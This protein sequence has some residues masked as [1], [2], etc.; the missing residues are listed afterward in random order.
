[1]MNRTVYVNTFATQKLPTV[2]TD[3]V[4]INVSLQFVN[5]NLQHIDRCCISHLFVDACI[6]GQ[7]MSKLSK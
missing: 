7:N 5:N 1:M 3:G 6:S 4:F 2:K